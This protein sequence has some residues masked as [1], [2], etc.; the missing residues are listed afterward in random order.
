MTDTERR[1]STRSLAAA[2][3]NYLEDTASAST[4]P[5]PSPP[6]SSAPMTDEPDSIDSSARARGVSEGE[7]AIAREA[8]GRG[9][10]YSLYLLY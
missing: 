4:S 9:P 6:R 7:A 10:R 3:V 1:R 8:R 2:A 5:T